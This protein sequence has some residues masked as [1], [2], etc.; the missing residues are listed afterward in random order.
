MYE[1]HEQS[2]PLQR[3]LRSMTMHRDTLAVINMNESVI[4]RI[5][6]TQTASSICALA[7]RT[8]A[9]GDSSRTSNGYPK[10]M[11]QSHCIGR[12][13]RR[14]DTNDCNYNNV[15]S[16]LSSRRVLY[17]TKPKPGQ[18]TRKTKA[19]K[20]LP[21]ETPSISFLLTS[22]FSPSYCCPFV[23]ISVWETLSVFILES[24]QD[25]RGFVT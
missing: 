15:Q 7:P 5:T 2:R 22:L 8:T 17:K 24:L 1:Y 16:T 4:C 13:Y 20:P 12:V 18:E 11:V 3:H 19:I 14:L 25:I 6:D 10:T 9:T 23:L 21:L